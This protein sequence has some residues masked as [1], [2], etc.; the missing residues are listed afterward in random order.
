M[1]FLDNSAA[2]PHTPSLTQVTRSRNIKW[3]PEHGH[4]LTPTWGYSCL[5]TQSQWTDQCWPL[6][7]TWWQCSD[8]WHM[9]MITWSRCY[10]CQDMTPGLWAAVLPSHW[11]LSWSHHIITSIS[12]WPH[13]WRL[14]WASSGQNPWLGPRVSS[15]TVIG[16]SSSSLSSSWWSLTLS[17]SPPFPLPVSSVSSVVSNLSAPVLSKLSLVTALCSTGCSKSGSLQRISALLMLW[18]LFYIILPLGSA[19][20]L[21]VACSISTTIKMFQKDVYNK[22]CVIPFSNNVF[23][24]TINQI[25]M[26]LFNFNTSFIYSPLCR[27]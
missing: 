22:Q 25:Y 19:F 17:K 26:Q 21:S 20:W 9:M 23:I 13:L 7:S 11:T 3:S 4:C 8:K 18:F 16:P 14:H 27:W 12:H 24:M 15:I 1:S 10:R 5:C 2:I 6:S